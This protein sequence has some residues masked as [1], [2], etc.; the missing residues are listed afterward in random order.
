MPHRDSQ[1]ENARVKPVALAHLIGVVRR[2]TTKL[3]AQLLRKLP[4]P[5]MMLKLANPTETLATTQRT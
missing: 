5:T 3:E 4:G 1:D 2:Q